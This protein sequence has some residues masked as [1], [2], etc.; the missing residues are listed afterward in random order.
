MFLFYLALCASQLLWPVLFV[1]NNFAVPCTLDILLFAFKVMVETTARA[2]V[3]SIV[4][5]R[6]WTAIQ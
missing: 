5:I 3:P 2:I 4:H 1:C 6:T